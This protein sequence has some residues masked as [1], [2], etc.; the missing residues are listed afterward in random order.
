MFN[1]AYLTVIASDYRQAIVD[2]ALLYNVRMQFVY[3]IA[4]LPLII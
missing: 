1:K 3:L 2:L 4:M